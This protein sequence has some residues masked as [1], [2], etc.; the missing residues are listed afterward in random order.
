[1]E[2]N[3]DHAAEAEGLVFDGEKCL[4]LAEISDKKRLIPKRVLNL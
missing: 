4:G 1:M 3:I 2:S